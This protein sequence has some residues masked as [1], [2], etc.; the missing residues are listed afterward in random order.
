M[1][2]AFDFQGG[3]GRRGGKEGSGL[4][5]FQG[6]SLSLIIVSLGRQELVLGDMGLGT[7]M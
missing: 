6:E 3:F 4:K 2:R 1:A 5:A 7:E